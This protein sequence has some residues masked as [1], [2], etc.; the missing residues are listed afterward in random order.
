MSL[1]LASL[2]TLLGTTVAIAGCRARPAPAPAVSPSV[3]SL[4]A[5]SGRF[6]A[7][8]APAAS[9]RVS[10]GVLEGLVVDEESGQPIGAV[11]ISFASTTAGALTDSTGRFRVAAVGG[12]QTIRVRRIGYAP[13]RID[14]VLHPDSGYVMAVGLTPTRVAVCR[15][16]SGGALVEIRLDAEGRESRRFLSMDVPPSAVVIVARDALTGRPPATPLRITVSDGAYRDSLVV[17][18]DSLG[19]VARTIAPDRP[20][21]YEVT[22]HSPGY[23][24]WRGSAAT[25]PV[26]G[27]PGEFAPAVFRAWLVPR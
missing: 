6:A 25:Q 7:S 19:R 17:T 5:E 12:T 20:G 4:A 1:R 2:R 16:S 8:Q 15:V 26:P 27:C 23:T 13:Y 9:A 10:P 24:A 11:Q 3:S 18:V 14:A 22:L 21:T